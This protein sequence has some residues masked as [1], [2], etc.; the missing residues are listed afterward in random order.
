MAEKGG[1]KKKKKILIIIGIITWVLS[2]FLFT[3]SYIVFFDNFS[4]EINENSTSKEINEDD[5]RIKNNLFKQRLLIIFSGIFFI[6][7]LVI[8]I[9]AYLMDKRGNMVGNDS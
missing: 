9:F 7:G 6:S 5:N 8:F 3:Y 4:S 1:T 2:V